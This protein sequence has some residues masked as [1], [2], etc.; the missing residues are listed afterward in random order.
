MASNA[1]FAATPNIAHELAD[2]INAAVDG[3]GQIEDL[4]VAGSSGTHLD[5]I[6]ITKRTAA[7]ET[8]RIFLHDG[9]NWYFFQSV[10]FG[11]AVGD[12][13]VIALG[14]DIPSGW[15]IGVSTVGGEDADV[16]C[17]GGD[18]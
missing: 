18:Y 6:R 1:N 7:S 11:A 2:T 14:F 17:F 9:T 4:V 12:S 3:T 5:Y 8:Y 13:H 16:F 10:T 15:K